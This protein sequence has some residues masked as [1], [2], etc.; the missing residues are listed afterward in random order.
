MEIK[1]PKLRRNKIL[2]I[3]PKATRALA[4]KFQNHPFSSCRDHKSSPENNATKWVRLHGGMGF[5]KPVVPMI[6][7]EARRKLEDNIGDNGIEIYNQEPPS[8]EIS[9]MGQITYNKKQI[10]KSQGQIVYK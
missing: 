7:V 2:K 9:C 4:K 1:Q 10:R 5:S 3:L 8:P 6:P